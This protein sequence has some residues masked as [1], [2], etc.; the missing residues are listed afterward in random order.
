M[1]TAAEIRN[2]HFKK[3]SRLPPEEQLAW[4]LRAG[5]SLWR[6]MPEDSK[7]YAK[8]LRNGWKKYLSR[9]RSPAKNY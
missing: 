3:F 1:N 6:L 8:R 5:Y 9:S 4:A 7:R 2:S